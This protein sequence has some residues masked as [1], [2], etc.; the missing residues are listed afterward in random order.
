MDDQRSLTKKLK[1]LLV[2]D[3]GF[4]LQFDFINGKT[5]DPKA[6]SLFSWFGRVVDWC[7]LAERTVLHLV[8]IVPA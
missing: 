7:L 6:N 1:L 8:F 3:D 5:F 4:S 2:K